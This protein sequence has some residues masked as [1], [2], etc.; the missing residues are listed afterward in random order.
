MEETTTTISSEQQVDSRDEEFEIAD[1]YTGEIVEHTNVI[2]KG[3]MY[4]QCPHNSLLWQERFLVLR[5]G[6]LE[7][8]LD[9]KL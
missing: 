8:Y 9:V 1:L 4:K 7:Y 3:I 6:I 5:P 2:R